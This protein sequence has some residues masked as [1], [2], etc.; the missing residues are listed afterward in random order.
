LSYQDKNI[1][2]IGL[3]KKTDLDNNNSKEI[4]GLISNYLNSKKIKSASI[5]ISDDGDFDSIDNLE[6]EIEV[7]SN[8]AFGITLKSYR[9]NKYFV[10]KKKI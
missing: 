3:G 9:F 4:G 6:K 10:D 7:I 1:T 5:I 2:F 8:I